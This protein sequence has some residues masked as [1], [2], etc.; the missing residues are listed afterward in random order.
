MDAKLIIVSV[1]IALSLNG[2]KKSPSQPESPKIEK[3]VALEKLKSTICRPENDD[4]EVTVE[5]FFDM[6]DLNFRCDRNID[7]S[8]CWFSIKA[9]A[10]DD[11]GLSLKVVQGNA[12]NNVKE[13]EEGRDFRVENIVVLDS[14]GKRI[15]LN[16]KVKVTGKASVIGPA[17]D[18]TCTMEASKIERL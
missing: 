11:N 17:P 15:A 14:I 16:Q 12:K 10:D 8:T 4:K 9:N 1:A 3:N 2:C 13:Y 5:G 7:N 18:Y 6:T